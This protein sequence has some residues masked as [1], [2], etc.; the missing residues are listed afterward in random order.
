MLLDEGLVWT[1]TVLTLIKEC[2][3]SVDAVD[4][5]YRVFVER[6]EDECGAVSGLLKMQNAF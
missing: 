1:A 2:A 5:Y 4:I 3:T 6:R